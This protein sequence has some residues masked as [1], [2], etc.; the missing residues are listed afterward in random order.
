MPRPLHRDDG[1]HATHEVARQLGVGYRRLHRLVQ[2][3]HITPT[4]PPTGSGSST[5]WTDDDVAEARRIIAR[6]D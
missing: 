3:G 4:V 1:M 6:I 5:R 2:A